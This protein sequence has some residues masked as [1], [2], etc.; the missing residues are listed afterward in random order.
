MKEQ[1]PRKLAAIL[2]ADLAGF[3]RHTGEDE[4]G[5]YQRLRTCLS[6]ADECVES[7]NGVIN[8][9]PELQTRH[10]AYLISCY[11]HLSKLDEVNQQ[12]NMLLELEPTFT[13]SQ[14]ERTLHYQDEEDRCHL[15]E[16]L[17]A[18]HIPD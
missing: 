10:Y 8:H 2:H 18:S 5:T 16:A 13:I 14:F 3:S 7:H 1:L 11:F 4:E 17:R 6:A 12:V 9:I 15:T